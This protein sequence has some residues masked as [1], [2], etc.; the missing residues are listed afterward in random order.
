MCVINNCLQINTKG[1]VINFANN[2]DLPG[3]AIIR[4]KVTDEIKSELDMNNIYVY[5]YDEAKKEIVKLSSGANYNEKGYIEFAINHNSKYLLVN[6]TIEDN[7]DNIQEQ[8]TV[9]GNLENVSFL[10]SNKVYIL[11]IAI[12][13]LIIII[14]IVIVIIDRKKKGI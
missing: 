5:Y 1:I 12:S 10:E 4:I 9:T 8:T 13:V 11:I 2:G 3:I 14:V 6:E 7:S